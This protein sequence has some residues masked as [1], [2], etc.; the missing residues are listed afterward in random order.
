MLQIAWQTF[1]QITK[2]LF[3]LIH[4][5]YSGHTKKVIHTEGSCVTKEIY[6]IILLK[7]LYARNERIGIFATYANPR[8][9]KL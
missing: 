9:P 5:A 4:S 7:V 2:I 1:I 6:N 8:Y 3:N